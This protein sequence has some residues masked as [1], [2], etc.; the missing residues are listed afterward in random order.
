MQLKSHN[1]QL[2]TP[3]AK[4]LMLPVTL[5]LASVLSLPLYAAEQPKLVVQITVDALRGDLPMRYL[6][7]M[8]AGG[9]RYLLNEGVHYTNAHFEHANTETI[10]GHVALATGAPPS[11]NGMVGNVWYDRS[12]NRLVYNIEDPNYN[13]LTQGGGVDAS[14]EVDTTQKA[15]ASDG[16]SPLNI[17][18][19]TFSDELVKSNN[20]QSRAFSVSFKDRGAVSMGGELGKA[21]WYSKASAGFVTSDY[22]YQQYPSWVEQWN[23]ENL[24]LKYD[25][26][27]W[28]L[29]LDDDKYLFH[30]EPKESDKTDLAGFGQQ[31]PHQYGAADSRY[32]TTKLSI[33]PVADELV[34][35]FA[36]TVIDKE[37]L[38]ASDVTDY[39][40]VSLSATDY[41]IHMFGPSSKEAEDNLLRLDR[42]LADLFSYIDKK[43]GLDNTLIV[44]SADHGAPDIPSYI[45][46]HGGHKADYFGVES[47]KASGIF[48]R[49]KQRFGL[50]EQVILQYADPY[51]YLDHE[52][53]E[54]KGV[55]LAL[56]QK[57]LADELVT[58]AGIEQVYTASDITSGNVD[59]SRVAKLVAQNHHHQRSG[60]LYLIYNPSVYIND[61]DGLKVAS[62]HGSPWRYDTHVPVIFAGMGLEGKKVADKITPY[63]IAPTLSTLLKISFPTGSTG[64]VLKAVEL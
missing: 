2:K 18:G 47:L 40:S 39:L 14:T 43:V 5:T 19:S 59:S 52:L 20:G 42:T 16:R 15:A 4:R 51:L 41:V 29:M 53:I 8:Q 31:F 45:H 24:H 44:L 25:N 28:Q 63:A 1:V 22:Y 60:D 33:S 62:V 9:F 7:N 54:A 57:F 13:L 27:A 11:V 49:L 50:D 58:I 23:D 3:G 17:N 46:H 12:V 30:H 36:K 10:V 56:V 34:A 35:D 21:F 37:Q 32:F 55:E 48:D 6:D 64:K 38:G 61:F 26:Q